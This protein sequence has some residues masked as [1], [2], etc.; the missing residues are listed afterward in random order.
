MPPILA[1]HA[2]ALSNVERFEEASTVAAAALEAAR[3]A[4]AREQECHARTTLGNYLTMA[5]PDPEA[6]L[7]ELDQVV[8][9]DR[10][11]G[12]TDGVVATAYGSLTDKLI[13]LG[14]FDE[15]AAM[16]LEAVDVCLELGALQ[17]SVGVAT[18]NAAEALFLSGR[19]DD[20]QQVLGQLQ[21]QRCWGM[22]RLELA[23]TALL[24]ASRGRDEAARPPSPP[25]KAS[26][27]ARPKPTP[28]S[29]RRRRNSRSNTGDLDAAHH[30]AVEGLDTLTG[31]VSFRR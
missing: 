2:S 18:F 29:A 15:A 13:R 19:W 21:E 27:A 12:D 14:R 5:S 17:S 24:T 25:W 1:A 23:F 8:A 4:G 30:A 16:A 26:A 6:G 22:E 11:L 20:C 31:S 3:A 9:M 10:E 28:S 7:R